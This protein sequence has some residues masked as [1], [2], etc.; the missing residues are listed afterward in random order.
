ME[1]LRYFLRRHSEMIWTIAFVIVFI[2]ATL[3]LALSLNE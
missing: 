2:A 3:T 1:R